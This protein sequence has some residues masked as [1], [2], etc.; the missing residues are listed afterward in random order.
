MSK[1]NKKAM[2][3]EILKQ[4]DITPT[5][6]KLA[7]ERYT[8]VSKY[9]EDNGIEAEFYPQGSFRLG[10]VTRPI[11]KGKDSDYDIDFVCQIK[12]IRSEKDG[13]NEIEKIKNE[14]G[15][16]LK[17]NETYNK[18]LD[19]EGRRCWTLIYAEKD[20]IGFHL[21]ILPSVSESDNKKRELNYKYGIPEKYVSTTI[22][23][24]NKDDDQYTWCTSNP[25]GY[26]EWFNE[27]NEPF[28]R[29]IQEQEKRALFE[30]YTDLY[31]SIEDVPDQLVKTPL[32]RVIQILKRHRDIRFS[33]KE[34]EKY[35]P[36]S[37]IITTLVAQVVKHYGISGLDTYNLLKCVVNKL[38][39]SINKI[40]NN[41]AE[42]GFIKRN[43]GTKEWYIPNPINPEENFA[44]KW[45][46]DNNKRAEM[47]FTW[48]KYVNKD[49]IEQLKDDE[50]ELDVLKA[51]FG[52]EICES[53]YS[54]Y[55]LESNMLSENTT[56]PKLI[57]NPGSP[58]RKI[59]G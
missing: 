58:W 35:K 15:D 33:G 46:E 30:N 51:S 20:G 26:S 18:I 10:T 39:E 25:I 54:K 23:I 19:D 59:N 31:D 40:Q 8:S 57:T 13:T 16:L 9:L 55:N 32:Q 47:F 34:D 2:I 4:L 29:M 38:D 11:K 41:N 37:M 48:I 42:F 28:Y 1:L 44:D 24:T 45:S 17:E 6:F 43:Q 56:G 3:N 36:I 50:V 53:A 21:D 52:Q 27:I 5:M 22:A 49:L 12:G 7:K 14:V